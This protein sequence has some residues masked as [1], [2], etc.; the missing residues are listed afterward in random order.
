[1]GADERAGG[2][3][4]GTQQVITMRDLVEADPYL[5]GKT[6]DYAVPIDWVTDVKERIGMWPVHFVWL[7]DE[8]ARTFGRPYPLTDEAKDILKRYEEHV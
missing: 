1:M 2:Q 3:K 6:Y 4:G 5:Q 7:Y 8:Q